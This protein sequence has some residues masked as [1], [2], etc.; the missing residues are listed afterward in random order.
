MIF[1]IVAFYT[2]T[3]AITEESILG[4]DLVIFAVSA[5]ISA[6][7]IIAVLKNFKCSDEF[8]K[9]SFL[10]IVIFTIFII[11]NSERT[12]NSNII[13][14]PIFTPPPIEH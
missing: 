6:I 14:L 3:G 10:L 5:I 12:M 7:I 13:D 2:Y 4:L 8:E 1:I 9:L 11:Y